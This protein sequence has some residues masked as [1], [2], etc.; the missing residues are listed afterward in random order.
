M[1]VSNRSLHVYGKTPAGNAALRSGR[2]TLPSQAR[3]ILILIDGRRS[4]GDL[5]GIFAPETVQSA[6]ALLEKEGF[7]TCLKHFPDSDEGFAKSTSFAPLEA[8]LNLP[9]AGPRR[10]Q[11]ST[12]IM[13]AIA[14]MM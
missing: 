11:A 2:G 10:H 3:R 4:L 8:P 14:A 6:L 5:A 1:D 13:A 9:H 7:V 12:Y